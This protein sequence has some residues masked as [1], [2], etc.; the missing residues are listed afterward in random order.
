MKNKWWWWQEQ[1]GGGSSKEQRKEK[2]K[3]D[4]SYLTLSDINSGHEV[5][6]STQRIVTKDLSFTH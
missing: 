6:F 1:C 3:R 4:N 2:F 5:S